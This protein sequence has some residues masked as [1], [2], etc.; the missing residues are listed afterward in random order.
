M[1]QRDQTKFIDTLKRYEKKMDNKERET[2]K[3]FVKRHKDDEDLDKISMDELRNM[4]EKYHTNRIKRDL[5]HFFK[6]D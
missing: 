5:D 6:K 2:Y 4:Y 3:M 1:S